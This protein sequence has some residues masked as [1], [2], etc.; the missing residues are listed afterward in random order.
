MVISGNNRL[1]GSTFNNLDNISVDARSINR[2]IIEMGASKTSI[3]HE[4]AEMEE[5]ANRYKAKHI[6]ES[7]SAYERVNSTATY[8]VKEMCNKIELLAGALES[9]VTSKK[10]INANAASSVGGM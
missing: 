5:C 7:G 4:N 10:S 1:T 8:R 3:A 6:S 9:D 2:L